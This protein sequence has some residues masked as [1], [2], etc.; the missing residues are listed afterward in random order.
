MAVEEVEAEEPVP[1]VAVEEVEAEEPVTEAAGEEAE[2]EETETTAEESVTEETIEETEAELVVEEPVEEVKEEVPIDYTPYCDEKSELLQELR[3]KD[4]ASYARAVLVGKL[5]STTAESMGLDK[6][7]T[8]AAG[9]YKFIGKIRE[10]NDEYTATEIAKEHNFPE[11]LIYLL[12]Q[13]NHNIVEQKEAAVILITYGVISNYSIIRGAKKDVPVEK[14]VD[15]VVTKKI[16]QGEFN[17]SGL[18]V[19]ECFM[20]REKLITL[21]N[22]QDKKHVAK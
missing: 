20:L 2:A 22:A 21:L 3:A 14:I 11:P 15:T 7:L 4:K 17:E 8:K 19:Q 1:E 16:F 10:N 13:L 18:N 12:D 6:D 5:A 9:L